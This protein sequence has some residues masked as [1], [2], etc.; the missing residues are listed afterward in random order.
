VW[1]GYQDREQ[2]KCVK[3]SIEDVGH[4]SIER[5]E[6]TVCEC[7]SEDQTL[8]TL[9]L[10]GREWQF[11]FNNHYCRGAPNRDPSNQLHLLVKRRCAEWNCHHHQSLGHPH[12]WIVT[13][14]QVSMS[15]YLMSLDFIPRAVFLHFGL[16]GKHI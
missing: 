5:S 14:D 7:D 3:R 9:R 10:N 11:I 1:H 6:E 12:E 15:C 16:C 4:A 2:M 8:T 13:K